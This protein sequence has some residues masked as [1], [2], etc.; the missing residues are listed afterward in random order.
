MNKILKISIWIL[1]IAT[2]ITLLGFANHKQHQTV[3]RILNIEVQNNQE[4]FFI[5]KK[6]IEREI[7]DLGDPIVGTKM[8][9]INIGRIAKAI[10]QIS[11]VK[12]CNVYK[13]L[14]GRVDVEVTQRIPIARVLNKDGSSYY[15]DEEGQ[16]MELSSTYTAKVPLITG[17]INESGS[18][19]SV[20]TILKDKKL[21]KKSYLDDAFK[22]VKSIQQSEFMSALTDYIYIDKNKDFVIVPRIGRQNIVVGDAQ[23]LENKFINL[24]SFYEGTINKINIDQYKTISIKY[25]EQVIGIK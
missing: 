10:K 13:T 11:A 17:E 24:R 4:I 15:L 23:N 16:I 7:L 22:L 3:C 5:N 12:D 8:D 18:L 14:D 9:D 2:A 6:S 20:S 1:V 25:N 19:G 21:A